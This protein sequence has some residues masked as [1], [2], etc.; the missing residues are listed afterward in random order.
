MP[1][2]LEAPPLIFAKLG[3]SLITDKRHR[4][5]PQL[6][7]L[8]RLAKELRA[9]LET[10]KRPDQ[11]NAWPDRDDPH[12]PPFQLVLGHGSGSFGHW[13]ASKFGTRNGVQTDEEW[14]GFARVSAAALQ[15][16]RLV[17]ESF[18]EEDVPVLS[19]Q[20]AASVLAKDGAITRLE[21]DPLY[22]ALG[23]GLVPLVFG[24]VAFDD[25]IGGTILSTEDIFV[26]LARIL[27]PSWILLFGNAPGVLDETRQTIPLI[28]PASYPAVQKQLGGSGY[29]DVTGGMADKVQRM[30]ALVH[31]QP[32]LRVRILSG[33]RPG[34]FRDALRDPEFHTSGTLICSQPVAP[35]RQR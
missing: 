12:R 6:A 18:I 15:L 28:T 31:E 5:T 19:L 25:E 9:A 8:R 2:P 29:T 21:I 17:T 10:G 27:K 13:E 7:I 4:S 30:V 24:D 23:H 33:S 16:N 35:H 32:D 14:H 26:Y 22:R 1:E 11:R 20:P 3:G 34:N